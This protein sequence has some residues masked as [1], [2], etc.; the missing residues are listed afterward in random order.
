MIERG[1]EP[2]PSPFQTPYAKLVIGGIVLSFSI[3]VFFFLTIAQERS[4]EEIRHDA[5]IAEDS[6]EPS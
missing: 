4:G 3:G 2:N 6:A 1:G 5:G